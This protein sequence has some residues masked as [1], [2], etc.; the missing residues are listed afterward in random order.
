MALRSTLQRRLSSL[1]FH[2]PANSYQLILALASV[3]CAALLAVRVRR[4]LRVLSAHMCCLGGMGELCDVR[5]G[6][7]LVL[8]VIVI[9]YVY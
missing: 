4:V 1:W 5:A 6:G 3:P 2:Q 9:G 7:A 8:G